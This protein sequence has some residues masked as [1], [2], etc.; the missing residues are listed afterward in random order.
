MSDALSKPLVR[1]T[2]EEK[3]ETYSFEIV[4]AKRSRDAALQRLE[5]ARSGT[6]NLKDGET[7]DMLA[8]NV[9]TLNR[10][11][12]KLESFK[13]KYTDPK[14]VE[15]EIARLTEK[16]NIYVERVNILK[17]KVADLK[18]HLQTLTQ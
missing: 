3:I 16:A 7:E 4:K 10:T 1:Q 2:A 5:M 8:A 9:A 17:E 12:E 11:V 6:L 15:A 13:D 14:S 18:Q